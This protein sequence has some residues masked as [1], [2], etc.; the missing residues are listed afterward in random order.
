MNAVE[1]NGL[2][3]QYVRPELQTEEICLAAIKENDLA[4]E[5]VRPEYR[6]YVLNNL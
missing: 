3:L 5:Y 4:L 1:K 6:D 2:A